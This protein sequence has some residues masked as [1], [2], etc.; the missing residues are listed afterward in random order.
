MRTKVTLVLLFLNVVL[1]AYVF[2]YERPL[3]TRL[4]ALEAR[5]AVLPPE[6]AGMTAFTRATPAGDTLAAEKR[7]DGSWW[8]TRPYEWPANPNAISRIH[9]EL[10]FLRNETKFKVADL[11]TTGQTLADY[12][13]AKPSLTFGFTAAGRTFDL[14]LGDDTKAGNRL[15]LLSPDGENIHVVNRG[16]ADSLGLGLADLRS[17]SIF[18][19]PVFEVRSLGVQTATLKTRLRRD[20][21]RWSFE[22]PINARANKADV[23]VTVNSLN[24][25]HARQFFDP[26]DPALERAALDQPAL[27]VT[28]EGNARRETLLIGGLA[29]APADAAPEEAG[30]V[31]YR[32]A[33]FEDKDV[34]FSTALPAQPFN[35]LDVLRSAQEKLRDRHVL[36]F[37]PRNISSLT[38]AAPGRPD[39]TLQRLEAAGAA[40]DS[41]Q[42]VLRGA[43]GQAP[44]TR[45]ADTAVV[46]GLLERLQALVATPR[47]SAAGS[48]GFL[49]DAPAAADLESY[50][51]NRPERE[52]TLTLATTARTTD[53]S[54]LKLLVGTSPERRDAAFAKLDNAPS[55]YQI[56]PEI[57]RDTAPDPLAYRQRL[58]RKLP[59]GARITGIKLVTLP[60]GEMIF[61]L[62]VPPDSDLTPEA[63][64]TASVPEAHKPALAVLL[65]Q[66]RTLRAKR[67]NSD[68]FNPE[69]AD[70]EG[71]PQ[72]W[73]FRLDVN[74]ALLGGDGAAQP[75]TTPLFLTRRLGGNTML[76][77]T[78][79]FGG[80]TFELTQELLDALF[81]LTYADRGPPPAATDAPADKPQTTAPGGL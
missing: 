5:R 4:A 69:R 55:I 61:D 30:T 19:I 28:L 1:F 6:V 14:R 59:A 56:T 11:A 51:F 70:H 74:L 63:V 81:T 37:D 75:A 26:R 20:A 42:L 73:T 64:A 8:L 32:F 80:V 13:L 24:S 47:A 54:S 2:Y 17:P 48:S 29:P 52:I 18:T 27:R 25:L 15:Y 49:T 43:D 77:G 79:E 60:A 35:L 65:E 21:A 78:A 67:F 33:R 62:S 40:A 7:A 3:R 9:N 53:P 66:M 10:Q 31:E 22:T 38:L 41:W 34:V 36:E 16:L 44:S 12:G 76:A 58:L 45:P 57:L 72:P 71:A 39:L 23:E 50:G 68:T 46:D